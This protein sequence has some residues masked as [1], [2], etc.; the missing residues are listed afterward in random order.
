MYVFKEATQLCPTTI[1]IY[2]ALIA[3]RLSSSPPVS[4]NSTPAKVLPTNPAVVLPVAR[5]AKLPATA[6]VAALTPVAEASVEALLAVK[7]TQQ[8]VQNATKKP[9]FHSCQ[10]ATDQFIA[11]IA[12]PANPMAAHAVARVEAAVVAAAHV[13]DATSF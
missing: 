13:A 7:C 1:K 6:A 9:K 11:E 5:P 12:S 4:K 10:A 8:L 3:N 2:N